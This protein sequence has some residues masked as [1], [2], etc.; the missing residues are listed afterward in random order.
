VKSTDRL[1]VCKYNMILFLFFFNACNPFA[2][3]YMS[4]DKGTDISDLY[5]QKTPHNVLT[6]F[7]YSYT[8]KDSIMYSD[9][10]DSSFIFISK[11]YNTSPPTTIKWGR[12]IDI[13]TTVGLFKNFKVIELI[14]GDT[15]YYK[16][17]TLD[18]EINISFQL[19][20]DGGRQY[21]TITGESL[22]YFIK[23]YDQRWL[24]TRWED[25]SSF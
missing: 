15:L 1:N 17:D 19:T 11:N 8:F 20:L 10:L 23:K 5:N 13:K 22:F 24:I 7:Q 6:K 9:L 12:D 4:K 21:P 3:P 14:W 2:P 18:A 25:R 16:K